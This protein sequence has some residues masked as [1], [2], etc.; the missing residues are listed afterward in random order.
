MEDMAMA[1]LS[2]RIGAALVVP[3]AAQRRPTRGVRIGAF[4]RCAPAAIGSDVW[5]WTALDRRWPLARTAGG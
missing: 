5:S 2:L 3:F 1:R 4:A